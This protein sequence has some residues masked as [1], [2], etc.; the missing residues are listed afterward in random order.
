MI[1]V[2]TLEE[3]KAN[4]EFT[5]HRILLVLV[6]Q[7]QYDKVLDPSKPVK[8]VKL[9]PNSMRTFKN[10]FLDQQVKIMAKLPLQIYRKLIGPDSVLTAEVKSRHNCIMYKLDINTQWTC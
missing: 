4:Q 5:Y 8:D 6:S 3:Q 9:D 1:Q 7:T 10:K 2:P